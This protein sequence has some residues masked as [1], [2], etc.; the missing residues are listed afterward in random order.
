MSQKFL[1][2]I[3]PKKEENES[4]KAEKFDPVVVKK[5]LWPVLILIV[6]LSVGL[7]VVWWMNRGVEMVDMTGWKIKDVNTW[8]QTYE[9]QVIQQEVFDALPEGTVLSQNVASGSLIGKSE[10][11][12]IEISAGFNPNE[13]IEL[14]TFDATWN[15]TEIIAYLEEN[16]IKNFTFVTVENE[17]LE[18]GTLLSFSTEVEA[19][20]FSRS[21]A[22]NFTIS[23]L[24][25]IAQVS[26]VDMLALST[27]QIDAWASENEIKVT[28]GYA[29]SDTVANNKVISQSIASGELID[30]NSSL[31]VVLSKGP[32]IKMVYFDVYTQEEAVA[33]AKLNGLNLSVET[34]YSN[35]VAKGVAI[36]Q[37]IA[38]DTLV[39][40]GTAFT[41]VYSLGNVVTV[42]SYVNQSL[43]NLQ[44]FV[45][46]QNALGANLSLNI[47]SSPSSTV[48]INKIISQSVKDTRVAMGSSI[49]VLVS[50]G[51]LV[52]VPN[53]LS[54]VADAKAASSDPSAFTHLDAYDEVM[55][56]CRNGLVCQVSFV[57]DASNRGLVLSQSV[58]AGSIISDATVIE[59]VIAQ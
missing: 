38:K 25:V 37:S 28:Y 54:T 22:I 11:L 33:W 41:L 29:F 34:Q 55:D 50:E 6:L 39:E 13:L 16:G 19:N 12:V 5:P 30:I 43:A 31:T 1:N 10:P 47:S 53:F 14:P 59:V 4:F 49:N 35:E 52:S 2:D 36:Y 48:S 27:A 45:E 23:S 9:I 42:N 8:A 58:V 18:A 15:K 24:P 21:D 46:A 20:A 56:L 40:T 26:V 17:D 51:N 57:E 32:A 44:S 7:G 3:T